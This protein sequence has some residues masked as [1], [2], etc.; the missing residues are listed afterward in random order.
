[1]KNKRGTE[2]K[3]F[4]DE[5]ILGIIIIA[6]VINAVVI[7]ALQ[8]PWQVIKSIWI[9]ATPEVTLI[10]S[11]AAFIFSGIVVITKNTYDLPERGYGYY[12][13]QPTLEEMVYRLPWILGFHGFTLMNPLPDIQYWGL[14]TIVWFVQAL[15]F[16]PGHA[17]PLKKFV[18][19]MVWFPMF[20]FV[21]VAPAATGHTSH[22]LFVAFLGRG[23]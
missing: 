13:L 6:V 12:L 4:D 20:F 9:I 14:W 16:A 22:N 3:M 17:S 7:F 18:L 2:R 19:G 5:I 10:T 21:G 11:L 1:M 8:V 23:E 15:V